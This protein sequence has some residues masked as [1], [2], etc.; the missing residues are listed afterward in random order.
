MP[1][2][3][4]LNLSDE[5]LPL[6]IQAMPSGL[7]SRPQTPQPGIYRFRLP[8]APAIENVFDTQEADDTQILLAVFNNDGMLYNIS[9]KQN[10]TARISNRFREIKVTNPETKEKEPLL[11][12]DFGM[13]LKA[14]NAVPD[15]VSNRALATALVQAAGTEF[16]AE[17][18]LTA[19]CNKKNPIWKQGKTVAG[20]FGC[21]RQYAVEGWKSEK[22]ERLQLPVVEGRVALR[23]TCPCDAE[24]RSWGQL[25][26]FR[27]V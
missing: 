21:G 7:G 22:S 11:I 12:S 2:I 17:H 10:Y 16:I 1:N 25:Q 5:P 23:F 26:G 3:N 14:L 13:L 24:L 27:S 4:K 19:T 18:T 9:L 20:K 6:N 15:R 8:E